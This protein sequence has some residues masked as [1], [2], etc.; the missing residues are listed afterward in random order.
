MV[1]LVRVRLGL[2][3]VMGAML[4]LSLPLLASRVLTNLGMVEL[5]RELGPAPQCVQAPQQ[6]QCLPLIK[7]LPRGAADL[8]KQLFE[9]AS[10][11]DPAND[12]AHWGA[13]RA[14]LMVGKPAPSALEPLFTRARTEPLLYVFLLR[15]LSEGNEAAR[16]VALYESAESPYASAPLSDTLALAFLRT[17]GQAAFEQAVRLRPG[18]LSANYSLWKQAEQAGDAQAAQYRTRLNQFPAQALNP[19]DE[20]LFAEVARVVPD[21]LHDQVWDHSQAVNVV[22]YL[23]WLHS[24]AEGV[25]Q[26][27][28]NLLREFPTDPEWSWYAGELYE[29]K[30]DLV[31]AEAMYRRLVQIAPDYGAAYAR[32]SALTG[33]PCEPPAPCAIAAQNDTRAAAELLS[34]SPTVIDL[35]PNLI[36]NGDFHAWVKSATNDQYLAR[37]PTKPEG[38]EAGVSLGP[39]GDGGLYALGEDQLTGVPL[40]RLGTLWRTEPSY[41]VY[42]GKPF[43]VQNGNYLLTFSYA[44]DGALDG[45]DQAGFLDRSRAKGS[46]LTSLELRNTNHQ[47]MTIHRIVN[48]LPDPVTVI[49]VI[50]KTSPGN[51]RVSLFS[52]RQIIVTQ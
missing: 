14:A 30:G 27:V 4:L 32:L 52:L 34:V 20:R 9:Q 46:I 28:E 39:N 24:E 18:D 13:A 5:A 42:A 8:P 22:A 38:W 43:S 3:F 36:E 23:V 10:T 11:L 33:L 21:L 26:L 48:G 41:A 7:V 2:L 1:N 40:P 50:L 44:S 12:S 35:G 47:L 31:R 29:R 16:V 51:L 45:Q 17:G 15:G 37:K 6:F 19:L 49:P 25:E